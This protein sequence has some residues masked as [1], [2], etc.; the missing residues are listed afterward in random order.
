[1]NNRLLD[2]IKYKT[3]GRQKPF[4]EFMGWTPQ[5]LTKLLRGDNFGLQPVLT[6]LEKLPEI[7]ARW[8]LFGDGTMLN[9]DKLLELR[10]ESY[11]R[12]RSILLLDQYIPVMSPDEIR[13]FEEVLNSGSQSC[14]TPSDIARW[15][16]L[17]QQRN[18]SI[19]DRVN[20]AIAKAITPCKQ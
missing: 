5:Y 15:D 11:S 12:A 4:A 6:L 19:N 9:D 1:M 16:M 13:H 10:M 8:F 2:I 17:L 3:A 7:N 14:F 20:D 18:N